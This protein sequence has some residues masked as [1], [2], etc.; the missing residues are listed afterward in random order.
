[1]E[2]G[3]IVRPPVADGRVLAR[4]D[5]L[6]YLSPVSGPFV[7]GEGR[8]VTELGSERL[9]GEG[10]EVT[11]GA[12]HVPALVVGLGLVELVEEFE[13]VK[14]LENGRTTRQIKRGFSLGS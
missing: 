9:P 4:M 3:S 14:Q 11:L 1:M 12:Q 10:R 7:C 8:S 2:V 5:E 13:A 6:G